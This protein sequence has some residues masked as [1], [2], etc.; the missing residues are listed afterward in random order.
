MAGHLN[1]V[2]YNGEREYLT[3]C[4]T[5]MTEYGITYILEICVRNNYGVTSMHAKSH[6]HT[7]IN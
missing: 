7:Y 6:M 5:K 4:V 1:G 2:N 3:F